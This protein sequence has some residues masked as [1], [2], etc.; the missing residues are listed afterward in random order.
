MNAIQKRRCGFLLFV[1]S[2]SF[3]VVFLALYALRQNIH[4]FYTPTQLF[5]QSIVRRPT[6]FFRLGGQVQPGSLRFLEG[7]L[8]TAFIVEDAQH[9][10]QVEFQGILPD[11]FREGRWVVVEGA[12][13]KKGIIHARQVLAKHGERYQ[14]PS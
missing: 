13:D 5:T 1:L 14:P 2:V 8:R 11:L 4:L 9:Q 6:Y 12:L 7:N 10:F 3:S